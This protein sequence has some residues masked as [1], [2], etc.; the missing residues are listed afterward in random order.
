MAFN[1]HNDSDDLGAMSE[2]NVTPLVDVMLV[3]LIIFMVT[4]PMLTQGLTVELPAAEGRSFEMQTNNPSKVSIV[5][6]GTVYVDGLSVGAKNIDLPLGTMLR[7]KR[8]KRA[9][10]EADQ[11]VPYGDVVR[12]IDIMNRAGVEQLGMV[13]RPLESVDARR[14]R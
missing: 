5:R 7:G 1:I 3:L 13:T 12:V 11:N 14:S 6:D 8:I 2:I 10:L 4:A 9:L